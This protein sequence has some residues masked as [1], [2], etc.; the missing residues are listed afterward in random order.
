MM[1]DLLTVATG[2]LTILI[3]FGLM[4]TFERHLS[5]RLTSTS[6]TLTHPSDSNPLLPNLLGTLQGYIR[7]TFI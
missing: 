3:L 6:F 7:A 2:L 1:D 4:V 5:H